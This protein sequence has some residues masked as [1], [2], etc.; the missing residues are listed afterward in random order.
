MPYKMITD[1]GKLCGRL[2]GAAFEHRDLIVNSLLDRWRDRLPEGEDF[3]GFHRILT[4][5]GDDLTTKHDG[6]VMIEDALR[7]ELR[8]DRQDRSLRDGALQEVRQLLIDSKQLLDVIY[9]P[10]ASET[11]WEEY[12]VEVPLDASELQRLGNRL[13]RNLLNPEFR[14]PPLRLDISANLELFAH[15]FDGPLEILGQ[16]VRSLHQGTQA[17][18]ASLAAKEQ[19]LEAEEQEVVLAGRLLEAVTAYAGHPGVAKRIR[20]SRHRARKPKED[21][22]T[23]GATEGSSSDAA[24]GRTASEPTGGASQQGGVPSDQ[25]DDASSQAS[26]GAT[27][28]A[29]TSD[30]GLET[31]STGRSPAALAKP[32]TAPAKAITAPAKPANDTSSSATSAKSSTA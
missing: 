12:D 27:D 3:M 28:V 21:A 13:R 8:E 32:F 22:T 15:R 5:V 11:F 30:S 25:G 10:G 1:V 16:S 19:L 23:E 17:S 24:D 20:L 2:A 7:S 31:G 4:Y 29:G 18:S 26:S 9:G 14:R 6:L